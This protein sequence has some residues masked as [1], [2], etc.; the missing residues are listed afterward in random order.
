MAYAGPIPFPVLEG[1]SGDSSH[2]AFAVLAG[3][4]TS[5]G[6]VQS[7]SG[8]G[9]TGQV[10]TSNGAGALPSFQTGTGGNLVLLS[11]QT[12][13]NTASISFVSFI[14]STYNNYL[15]L[16]SNVVPITNAAFLS[17]QLSTNNGSTYI[18]T[19]YLSGNN[20]IAYNASTLANLT[21]TTTIRA[22]Y[23]LSSTSSDGNG[24]AYFFLYNFTN[25]QIPVING[26]QSGY[27]NIDSTLGYNAVVSQNTATNIN[28]FQVAMSSG[29]ISTG[30][31]SLF[32]ILE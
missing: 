24:N 18:S 16:F 23:Q 21:S 13:S 6:A 25:G 20:R 26:V 5:T 29:N 11:S 8:V 31:F 30:T 22:T 7:I 19:N 3:G 12:A 9:T 10:L 17:M 2:T 27:S 32:G 14:T 1:G 15:F 28:A 4:T